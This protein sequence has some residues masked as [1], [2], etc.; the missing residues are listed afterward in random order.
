MD[1]K[2]LTKK[3]LYK[4]EKRRGRV[5]NEDVE[6]SMKKVPERKQNQQREISVLEEAREVLDSLKSTNPHLGDVIDSC[7]VQLGQIIKL[8]YKKDQKRFDSSRMRGG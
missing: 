8:Q 5:F 2:A 1:T 4:S 6:N 7:W 3:L